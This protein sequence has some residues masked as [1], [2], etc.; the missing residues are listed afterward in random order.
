MSN[1]SL[2]NYTKLSPHKRTRTRKIS[3]ITIHHMAGKLS[4]ERCGNVFCGTRVASSNYGVDSDGR[5]G[6]YVEEKHRSIA[7]SDTVNDDMAVTIEVA[8]D[9][10]AN[11]HVSDKALQKTIELCVDI[12]KRNDIERLNFTGDKNGNLTMHK[13]FAATACP[14]PYLES[15][16]QYIADEVNKLLD[17]K[18]D[19]IMAV[20]SYSVA[21][22]GNTNLSK[23]F[24]VSEFACKDG[25]DK[26]LIDTELIN[27]LQRIRDHFGKPVTINSAYRNATYNAKIGGV[28][29]SQHT[30][31]TAADIVVSGVSPKKVAQ[32]AEYIMP[33]KG[34]IGEYGTFTHVDVRDSRSR[35]Q[36][37]GTEVVVGG[38]PG[39]GETTKPK[40]ELVSANDIIWE[41][42]N[43]KY[44]VEI[45]DVPRAVKQLEEAKK[46]ESSLYWILRKL[47]N[48]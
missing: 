36:N 44:G 32:Y 18:G 27:L 8:N 45:L 1:S 17:E 21:K 3:K 25:S 37:F 12:C 4:V 48:N 7:S 40:K 42:M 46:V 33:Q 26:V 2:V 31:G 24:K 38:F 10:G 35:W 11:W 41:L 22:D 29:N 34:G 28:S 20:K 15:K 30:K 6:M 39:Y 43:G 13:Y 23:N 5:I 14:G 16:F 19:E 47:V 9:G